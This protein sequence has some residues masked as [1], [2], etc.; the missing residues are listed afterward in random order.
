VLKA[1]KVDRKVVFQ[2]LATPPSNAV[3]ALAASFKRGPIATNSLRGPQHMLRQPVAVDAT[4]VAHANPVIEQIHQQSPQQA[5]AHHIA[6]QQVPPRTVLRAVPLTE[7]AI[8]GRHVQV[9]FKTPQPAQHANDMNFEK[10][11]LNQVPQPGNR[12]ESLEPQ[13]NVEI[14]E[15][16]HDS[17]W[18]D[19]TAR[20]DQ[21]NEDAIPPW[22]K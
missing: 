12:I 3:P 8:R 7:G 22:R 15:P 5:E 4:I 14:A 21:L 20:N 19:R 6:T 1:N 18:F 16:I 2:P 17:S 10:F 11:P 13:I 9:R